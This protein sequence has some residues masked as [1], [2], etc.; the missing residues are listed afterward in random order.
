M[1]PMLLRRLAYNMLAR[2]C[3]V[4]QRIEEKRMT[5]DQA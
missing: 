4:A 2:F 3:S 1:N 5:P